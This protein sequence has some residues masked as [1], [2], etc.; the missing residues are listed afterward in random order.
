MLRD[1]EGDECLVY[2]LLTNRGG[3]YGYISVDPIKRGNAACPDAILGVDEVDHQW[4][5]DITQADPA[6]RT[7]GITLENGL[8]V[9]DKYGL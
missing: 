4:A 9:G 5:F 1:C 2:I 6:C 7:F 8:H 3:R